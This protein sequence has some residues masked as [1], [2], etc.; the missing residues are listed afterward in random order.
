MRITIICVSYVIP[1]QI[2]IV[3]TLIP[4]LNILV[5]IN[6]GFSCLT[7]ISQTNDQC[8]DE[9]ALCSSTTNRC[10]CI[11]GYHQDGNTCVPSKSVLAYPCCGNR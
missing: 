8:K 9:N 1:L 6:L 5:G 2:K 11:R 7:P 4:K 3:D 10:Q